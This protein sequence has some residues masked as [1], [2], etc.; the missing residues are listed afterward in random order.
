MDKITIIDMINKNDNLLSL[1]Q[2]LSE[3]LNEISKDDFNQ[4]SLVAIILKDASITGNILKIANSPFYARAQEV[5]TINHAISILG[6]TTVKCISLSSSIFNPD[7]LKSD[8]G[9]DPQEL[10]GYMLSVAAASE[11]IAQL[12][13][14]KAPE[15]VLIAGLLNNIGIMFL[16]HHFPTEYKKIIQSN[17]KSGT[18]IQA[19]SKVFGIN[20]TEIGAQLGTIWKLPSFII[21]SIKNSHNYGSTNDDDVTTNIVKLGSLI[22]VD[23][24]SN[25]QM[26][27][28]LRMKAIDE[29]SKKLNISK[30]KL[31]E[32]SFSLLQYSIETAE[33]LGIDIGSHEQILTKANK[34]IWKSY[35]T[36]ENLFKVRQDL[37]NKLLHEEHKRGATE[38]KNIT[39]ATLSHYL[40]NAAM[41]IY[42]RSQLMRMMYN[43]GKT[44]KLL[45][46]MDTNLTVIDNAVK[47]FVAVLEEMKSVSPIDSSDFH[48]ISDALNLDDKIAAREKEMAELDKWSDDQK[49]EPLTQKS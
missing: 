33:Y 43:K 8:A 46:K 49:K 1:P 5:T 34:E 25:Y 27:M 13:G 45:E 24:F 48:H 16:I 30:S 28:D 18:L 17:H 44:D 15:E 36:I 38:Q 41:A 2:A 4:D 40:N 23:S 26:G 11:K 29:V 19:E 20:H 39:M 32:V 12:I 14:H 31:D 37:E 10:F 22:T 3:I 6:V 42:G 35:L 21:E 47:R 9:V 7:K